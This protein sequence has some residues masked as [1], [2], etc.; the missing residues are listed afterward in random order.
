MGAPKYNIWV[1][2]GAA[3]TAKNIWGISDQIGQIAGQMQTHS[4]LTDIGQGELSHIQS[5]DF[6]GT[7]YGGNLKQQ[8]ARANKAARNDYSLGGTA[9]ARA[10]N[11]NTA[12]L[13]YQKALDRRMAD[14]QDRS[15]A[16]LAQGMVTY[17]GQAGQWSLTDNS[18][19]EDQAR[20]KAQQ[21]GLQAQGWNVQNSGTIRE[22]KKS[23]W[24]KLGAG[25]KVA[26]GIAGA[27]AGLGGLSG[28]GGL[29]KT[30][31]GAAGGSY[32]SGD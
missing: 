22:K 17:P 30:G 3:A 27:F 26:G 24:D 8:T 29:F 7:L 18:L 6:G 15:T 20:L 25:L 2:P 21:A 23:F 11:P 19:L 5:G 16:A 13:I 32:D 28:I 12:G 1:D 9:L 31:A 4:A 14:N 10:G